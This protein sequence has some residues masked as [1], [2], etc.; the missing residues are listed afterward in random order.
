MHANAHLVIT[1]RAKGQISNAAGLRQVRSGGFCT[2]GCHGTK[3]AATRAASLE[4]HFGHGVHAESLLCTQPPPPSP[5]LATHY[6]QFSAHSAQGCS[7]V[8]RKE[9]G[10]WRGWGSFLLLRSGGCV[11][12]PSPPLALPLCLPDSL[13]SVGPDKPSGGSNEDAPQSPS[14]SPSQHHRCRPPPPPPVCAG[15]R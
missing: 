7:K 5:A 14:S 15:M 11:V 13:S 1:R 9:R 12:F 6:E 3:A 10:G 4:G 8:H 2:A